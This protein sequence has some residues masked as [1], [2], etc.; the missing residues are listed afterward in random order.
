MP[1][2]TR[3]LIRELQ[4]AMN[5]TLDRLYD[6]ADADLAHECSHPCGHGPHGTTSIW[7]LL[8]NDVDH[9]K[10]HAAQVL[11]ARHDLRLMQ[12]QPQRMLA[13]W[14]TQRAALIGTLVGLDDDALD[15]RLRDGDWSFR[16]M[17]EHVIY[18]ER[19]S[20]AAGLS[21]VT[22]GPPWTADRALV[23]GGPV[24]HP[25]AV[26]SALPNASQPSES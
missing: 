23:Y 4:R 17:V 16:E 25:R 13:E 21:D 6:L 15:R 5:E 26:E 7:H 8:A 11:N 9:E 3:R 18:W 19:D 2:E 20:I 22:G 10:M 24:P 1:G 14:L 12:T